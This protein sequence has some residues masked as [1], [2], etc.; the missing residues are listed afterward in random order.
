M[1]RTHGVLVVTYEVTEMTAT[2][3]DLLGIETDAAIARRFQV[4]PSSVAR[5]RYKLK[6]AAVTDPAKR[7]PRKRVDLSDYAFTRLTDGQ[8]AR[9][10]RC[11]S[12]T[13]RRYRQRHNIPAAYGPDR[14]RKGVHDG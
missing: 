2:I 12:E 14:R 5:R 9:L 6:I 3:E 8:V 11:H 13:V 1:V 7:Y 4:S 10:A